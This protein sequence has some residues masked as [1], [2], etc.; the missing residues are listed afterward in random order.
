MKNKSNIILTLS[1]LIVTLFLYVGIS[2]LTDFTMFKVN[3]RKSPILS[4]SMVDLLAYLVPLG[5]ILIAILLLVPKTRRFGFYISYSTMVAFTAYIALL[6]YGYP[7]I[8]CSCGGILGT[9]DFNVHIIFN[10]LFVVIAF[11]GIYL[12][13]N[14]NNVPAI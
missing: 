3:M 4:S 13:K 10:L 14:D 2:K 8:A 5:E 9:M 7:D 12:S 1:M 6:R 11:L